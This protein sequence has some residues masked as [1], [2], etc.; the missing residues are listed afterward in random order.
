MW[1][2]EKVFVLKKYNNRAANVE[3]ILENKIEDTYEL[4]YHIC[5]SV[6]KIPFKEG[7]TLVTS[8]EVMMRAVERI[9]EMVKENKWKI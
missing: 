9:N 5:D 8:I 2:W 7:K 1:S 6:I 3:M 4:I